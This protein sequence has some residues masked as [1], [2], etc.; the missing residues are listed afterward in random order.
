MSDTGSHPR[1]SPRRDR[2]ATVLRTSR[3]VQAAAVAVG[4]VVLLAACGDGNSVHPRQTPLASSPQSATLSQSNVDG[5]VG[6]TAGTAITFY[7]AAR[8]LEQ[9][10]WGPT[11]AAVAEVQQLGLSGWIDQQ[12]SLPPTTLNAPQFVINHDVNNRAQAEQADHWFSSRVVDSAIGGPDQLRQRVAWALFNFIPVGFIQPYGQT[13]YFNMMQR[14]ALGSFKELLREVTLNPGMGFF[15]NNDENEASRPNENY[16]RELMQLFS[17]GL[18]LLNADGTVR[19]DAKGAP[20]ETYTQQDVKEATRALS[21]WGRVWENNLPSS[22]FANFGKKMVPKTGNGA[23]D[24]GAKRVLGQDIPAGQSIQQDL[25]RLLDILIDHPNTAP[26]VSKRL[27]QSMVSSDP[28]PEY[29]G[30]VSRVFAQSRGDLK[31]V[32]KAILLDPEARAGDNPSRQL[33]RIGKIKEPYLAYTMTLRGMGCR[34]AVGDRNNTARPIW[35]NQNPF[36]APSVFGYFAPNHKTPE[37]QNLAPEEKLLTAT[38]FSRRVG[39]MYWELQQP[40]L[41]RAAGCEIDRIESV[42]RQSDEAI[43]AFVAQRYL[44]G[45]M[46]PPLRLSMQTLLRERMSNEEPLGKFASVLGLALA[47]PYGG[48]VK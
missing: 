8:L 38:E 34:I 39:G 40:D 45:S 43:I 44:R 29:L 37:S 4:A 24:S 28:S 42:A 9:A 15:L 3:Y 17:V 46:P 32:V 11:P 5:Q 7:Q 48:V 13:E 18:V 27:I 47:S 10:S 30:R 12:L 25:D 31:A 22:N 36:A 26:F 2:F 1:Q 21:G 35:S 19:R 33:P 41:F 23:H 20:I 6:S 16:A 14:S